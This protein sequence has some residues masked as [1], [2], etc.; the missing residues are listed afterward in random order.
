MNRLLICAFGF[1][2]LST[3]MPA[4]DNAV[5]VSLIELIAIPQK[6]DLKLVTVRG[7]LHFQRERHTVVAVFLNINEEDAKNMLGNSITITPNRQMLQDQETL[8][9]MYVTVTGVFHAVKVSGEESLESGSISEV[10]T[11]SVWSDPEHPI[12]RMGTGSPSLNRRD[13]PR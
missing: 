2:L 3:S 12:G 1:V 8:D 9:N 6:L 13:G 5:P 11:C 7:F 10:R 4:Y